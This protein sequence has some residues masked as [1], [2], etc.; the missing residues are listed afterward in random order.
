MKLVAFV[1]PSC[2]A[3]L[4]VDPSRSQAFCMYCGARLHI[5]DEVQ[6][7]EHSIS[8]SNA[9]DAGY[10]FEKGRQRAMYEAASQPQWQVQQPA[11]QPKKKTSIVVWFLGWLFIFP[12]PLT[13]LL[14]RKKDMKPVL[15][16]VII[17]L[18]WILYIGWVSSSAARNRAEDTSSPVVAVQPED[19]LT[20]KIEVP[21]EPAEASSNAIVLEAGKSN[22]YS[23]VKVIDPGTDLEQHRVIFDVPAGRYDAK[24][25]GNYRSQV[26]VYSHEE[27]PQGEWMEPADVKVTLIE[28]GETKEIEVPEG[29]YIYL[30]G[31][32]KIALTPK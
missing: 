11:P 7:V 5:D 25:I 15:K 16:Y 9:E 8:Y 18:A 4:E 23:S 29:Y 32:D 2:G 22:E 1:C 12:L 3:K 6:R 24:N 14:L 31:K 13:V 27:V 30:S 21:S 17:A 19:D 20:S 10:Q 28:V 26:N